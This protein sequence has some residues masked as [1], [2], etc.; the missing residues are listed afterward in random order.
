MR[1][2]KNGA[3]IAAILF[4]S[5]APVLAQQKLQAI[6]IGSRIDITVNGAFF[7]SYRF[8]EDG[9]Y[10]FFFPVN[11]PSGTSATSMRNG[12]YPHHSSLFFGCDRVN[13]GN[14]WQEGLDRGRIVSEGPKIENSSGYE[15]VI[16][17]T[18]NWT[19]DGAPQPIRDTRRILLRAPS[20]S[21]RQIDFSVT[22]EALED[23]TI[24]KTNHSLFSARMDPD[25]WRHHEEC[26]GAGGEKRNLRQSIALAGLLW[27]QGHKN[28]GR[29]GHSPTSLQPWLPCTL[30][31][32]R[33]WLSFPH[34]DVL[35][36]RRQGYQPVQKRNPSAC[37]PR[38]RF[39]RHA[40]IPAHHKGLR[41]VL[42]REANVSKLTHHECPPHT[43]RTPLGYRRDL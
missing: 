15:I 25:I 29:S 30:V 40:G 24:S 14:Y 35:A 12:K 3:T 1:S 39:F 13:E 6:H 28:R 21:L 17:D 38:A 36:C 41:R 42:K 26:G 37:L 43:D 4:S 20:P 31:H 23:V 19:R 34:T 32:P 2:T 9:K 16:S 27:H 11:G 33:L 18:C 10:P 8:S 22:L 5:I 7:T